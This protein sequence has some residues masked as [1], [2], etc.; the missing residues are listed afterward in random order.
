M[1]VG[2]MMFHRQALALD[3]QKTITQFSHRT[4]GVADHIEEVNAIC[5]TT[6]GFL[7]I[8][9]ING[10]F[11][12]DGSA[13]MQWEPKPDDPG[14]PGIPNE[15]LGAR[16][17]S[18]WVGGKGF[19]VLLRDGHSKVFVL[20]NP[21]ERAIVDALC[22][23]KE[24]TVW[25]GTSLGLYRLNRMDWHTLGPESGL[26]AGSVTTAMVDGENTIWI[27]LG[28]GTV[29]FLREGQTRFQ[30]GEE[31]SPAATKLARAPD[32]KIWAAEPGRSVR[33]FTCDQ[34]GIHLVP[35]EIHVG[36]QSLLIDRDG[37]LWI[38]TLGDG[39]RRV[40]NTATLGTEDVG[41]FSDAIDKFT[42]IDG[43]S[44]DYVRCAFEDREGV[45]WFGTS[46]GV[47]CFRENKITALSVREG[48]PFDQNLCVQVTPDGSVWAGS[49]PRGFLQINS[50]TKQFLDRQ[51]LGLLGKVRGS[52]F[53][54]CLYVDNGG[55]LISG[56]GV[57]VAILRQ[58][59]S[60]A[61]L[62]PEVP[63]LQT[64]V[65]ITRDPAGGLWLCDRNVG[66]YRL[67]DG[68]VQ[69]FPELHREADGW[70]AVAH[71]D[72]SGRVWLGLTTGELALYENGQFRLFSNK[73]GLFPGQVTAIISDTNGQVWIA[74]KGGISLFQNGRFQTL[75]RASGLPFDDLFAVLQDD[76]NYFWLAGAGGLFRVASGN[77]KSALTSETGQVTGEI[78]DP[79]D[80]LRGAIRHFPVGFR[81]V[82]GPMAAK[83]TDGKLWFATTAGL[84]VIDPRNIPRNSLAPPIR[85]QQISAGGKTYKSFE[86]LKF[87][88]RIRDCVIDYAGLSFDNPARVH[89]K[90][91]L[92]GYDADW[93][94]AGNRRQAFYSNLRPATYQF[95]VVACN[96]DGVWNKNGDTIEFTVPPAFYESGW[97]HFVAGAILLATLIGAYTWR[98]GHLKARQQ[99]LQE[100]RDLLAASNSSLR[101][102]ISE[103]KRA[104]EALQEARS[105]LARVTRVTLMGELAASIA[106]EVN[107]P[108]A[109]VVT[110]ANASLN[111][112]ANK[113]PNIAKARESV[114]RILRDGTR[115]G[116]VLTRIRSL[117]KKTS[118]A[119]SPV[120]VND[121]IRGVLA[122]AEGDVRQKDVE[123]SVEL[124]S[125]L[126]AIIGDSVQ[127]QQVLLNLIIN[128]VEAMASVRDRGKLLRIRSA[129]GDL[130]GM[131]AISAEVIDNGTGF[132]NKDA[133][134]LFEA[135][136]TS[137]PEGMGMGLWVSRSIIEAH[138][139]RLTARPNESS[140][141]TFQILLPASG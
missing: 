134:R 74:G 61:T 108:L 55:D 25:A 97:F 5:Q 107:Q 133:E 115:A 17:G 26:P 36:S 131:P 113:P 82:G 89:Y 45:L 95:R 90:Y 116:D 83:S 23:T 13:F 22:E 103:R 9:T 93:K 31:R 10:L 27:G 66:V 39:L 44:S 99:S 33:A 120:S 29:A 58:N 80:G 15:L 42:Q 68:K 114:E 127:L 37:S 62:L 8:A 96:S 87:P 51:W 118:P 28:S 88:E 138:G 76:D 38:A 56:T 67:Q 34:H 11:R 81:G 126:P 3:T 75:N 64:V 1:A 14:L 125:N 94:D 128:A 85:I 4:W 101:T 54:H 139:G 20:R 140:G 129:C 65:A 135:F 41:Q 130:D 122:L 73:D 77:L 2:S 86:K 21:E 100:S 112:L 7:W 111:W 52:R 141:A 47:D 72:G 117:L 48:L 137:K 18:L 57:G 105:D 32:G 102:E 119:K 98:I 30:L 46:A 110:S 24:G 35:P 121:I 79:S 40:R 63:D 19:I 78:F 84:A 12:F 43:L 104:E 50:G 53:I 124:D 70:V 106:H 91:K 109:G 132:S 49:S 123:L 92:E 136:Y 71:T 69:R 60:V 6:D 59:E 16:D